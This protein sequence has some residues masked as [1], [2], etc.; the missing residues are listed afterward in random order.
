[1]SSIT[2][3]S[4]VRI[5]PL[6]L[7]GTFISGSSFVLGISVRCC[8]NKQKKMSDAFHSVFWAAESI[9]AEARSLH[10]NRQ[11]STY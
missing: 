2:E 8:E 4:Y 6:D 10:L 7:S 5:E 11:V 9:I 3:R 1:M